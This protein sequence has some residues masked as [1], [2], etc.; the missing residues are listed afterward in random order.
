MSNIIRTKRVIQETKHICGIIYIYIYII[1]DYYNTSIEFTDIISS[2]K[3][4]LYSGTAK[5][6]KDIIEKY[7]FSFCGYK[8][9]IKNLLLQ[10]PP[11][12]LHW[13]FNHYIVY[14]GTKNHL[15]YLNDPLQGHIKLNIKDFSK[16]FTGFVFMIRPI[17]VGK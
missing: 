11:F 13:E 3:N 10:P 16:H 8:M 2:I 1:L 14:E 12:I 9:S 5:E 6:L 15:I 17:S 7:H 4:H